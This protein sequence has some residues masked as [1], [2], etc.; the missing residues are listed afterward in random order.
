MTAASEIAVI[1]FFI[2]HS[3]CFVFDM[4]NNDLTPV[5]FP[6]ESDAFG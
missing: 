2:H 6:G 1:S 4:E 5:A 3:C